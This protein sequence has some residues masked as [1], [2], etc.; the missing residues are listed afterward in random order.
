MK[1]VK[2]RTYN[3]SSRQAQTEKIKEAILEKAK[4]LFMS[5][6]FTT[7]TIE[8]IAREADVAGSTIYA[9]FKSKSGILRVLMDQALA[10]EYFQA[11]VHRWRQEKT[12][13]KR[14][15]ITAKISRQLYDAEFGQSGFFHS[16][17]ILDPIFKQ[18]EMEKEQRRYVRQEEVIDLLVQEKALIKDMS[19]QKARDV[20]WAFT[21]R[22]FY[23]M[24]VLERGWSSDEYEKWLGD[25][26]VHTLLK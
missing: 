17:S 11:L 25:V 23:R 7:V 6:G 8:D 2:K 4:Q 14:F 9:L 13:A 20:L 5:K 24:L 26:L 16:A 21:G 19:I 15:E 1:S 22:D 10:P 12:P 3:S 18:L